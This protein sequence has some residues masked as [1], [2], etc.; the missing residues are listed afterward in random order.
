MAVIDVTVNDFETMGLQIS[1]KSKYPWY[2]KNVGEGFFIPREDL[3]REDY[4][5]PTPPKLKAKGQVWKTTKGY[6]S[7]VKKHGI[8]IRRIK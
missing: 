1:A 6:H 5:P 7:G 2:T 8:F 3:T 4:R